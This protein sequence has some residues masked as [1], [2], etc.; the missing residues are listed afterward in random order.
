MS[1]SENISEVGGFFVAIL[2]IAVVIMFIATKLDNSKSN[3]VTNKQLALETKGKNIELS[4]DH[5][6]LSAEDKWQKVTGE[7]VGE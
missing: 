5:K 4:V 7:S 6:K 3:V 2:L 1:S